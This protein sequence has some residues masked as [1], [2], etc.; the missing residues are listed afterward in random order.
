MQMLFEMEHNRIHILSTRPLSESLIKEVQEQGI[1]IDESPFIRTE[2]IQSIEVQQEIEQ[3]FLL[4]VPVVFTSMNAVDAVAY[5]I[6]ETQPEWQIYCIGT[7]TNKLAAKY[8]GEASIAGTA[9]DAESLAELIVE[10]ASTDEV[11]F[12]C[13]DQ[14]RDELPQILRSN[15]IEVNEI[16]VY[17]TIALP[18]KIEKVYHGILFFSPS[19]AESFFRKNKLP[20]TTILFAIGNTTASEIKK[21]TTNKIIISNEPGKENLVKK[22][23]EYFSPD[24]YV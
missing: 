8:F 18:H 11:I 7:T 17:Q 14:R 9:N 20:D 12:F 24:F 5:Y 10:A 3:A 13:G 15:D 22:M 19:A 23:T 21:Y 6:E 16:T 1:Y 2:P 4:T